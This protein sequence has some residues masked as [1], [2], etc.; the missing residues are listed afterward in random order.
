MKRIGVLSI[1]GDVSEHVLALESAISVAGINARVVE[2]K[3]RETV[4]QVDALV[5]PGGESTTM[6]KLIRWY[7]LEEDL[8]R[9]VRSGI[10]IL[11]TCAG[12]VLLAKEGDFQVEKTRQPLLGLMDM[13]VSRNAFGRQRESFEAKLDIPAIGDNPYHGVFIRA[14][15]IDKLWGDA[16]VLCMHEDRI[17]AARQGNIIVTS[18]HPE[19]SGDTR[20]HEYFLNRI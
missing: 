9:L 8:I 11:A 7:K 20:L 6:G 17:V 14:P 5:F 4:S 12:L 10:P 19:L 2:V 3:T 15:A 18:F 16:K 13:K 1:Q